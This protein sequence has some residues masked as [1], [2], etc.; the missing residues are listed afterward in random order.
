MKNQ[1]AKNLSLDLERVVSDKYS[2][3][4]SEYKTEFRQTWHSH[5]DFILVMVL[6][7]NVREQVKCQDTVIN[8]F[9]VGIKAPEIKHTDHFCPKGVRVIRLSLAPKFVA[10]LKS[11]SLINEDWNW[12][13]G[14]NAVR[15]FLQIGNSLLLQNSE[16]TD[17]IHELLAAILPNKD[18]PK[19]SHPPFWLRRAKQQLDETFLE[20]VRLSQLAIEAGVHP[21]YFARKFQQFFGCNVG[22]YVRKL[23]VQKVHSLLIS[24]KFSLSQIAVEVG[25]SDQSHLTRT[26]ANEF[27][28]TPAN[29][30]KLLK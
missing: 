22:N 10:Q 2:A 30:R 20:G 14:S 11:E 16:I 15:P 8:A 4:L 29:L 17:E 21:V 1:P 18:L 12:L 5:D 9:D 6:R 19:N 13:K 7:G 28:I 25:F 24:G 27:G 3:A 23:Q 26:F